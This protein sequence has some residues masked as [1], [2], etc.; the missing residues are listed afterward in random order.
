MRGNVLSALV[1]T[2][3]LL[4]AACVNLRA[5]DSTESAKET[6]AKADDSGKAKPPKLEPAKAGDAF[7]SLNGD[8]VSSAKIYPTVANFSSRFTQTIGLPV[9]DTP[10]LKIGNTTL[11]PT[12][13]ETLTYEDN[14]FAVSRKK[15]DD[16]GL[17]SQPGFGIR[18][19]FSDKIQVAAGYAFGWYDYLDDKARDYL[20]HNANFAL[21][22]SNIGVDGLSINLYDTYAQTGN[23]G[24]LNESYLAFTRQ[25]QNTSGAMVNYERERIAVS[26]SYD[27]TLLN[28]FGSSDNDYAYHTINAMFAYKVSKRIRPYLKYRFQSYDFAPSDLNNYTMNEVLG[29]VIFRP[30]DQ[31]EFDMYLG[32]QRSD[33]VYFDN[34]TEGPI[35]G[36]RLNYFHNQRITAHFA[37][38]RGYEVGVLT[39][40]MT[41]S[42]IEA[43]VTC[44]I[45]PELVIGARGGWTKE[46]RDS[47]EDQRTVQADLLARYQFRRQFFFTGDYRYTGRETN[48]GGGYVNT[49]QATIGFQWRY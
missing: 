16:W 17:Y 6:G 32:G 12:Y 2:G 48:M 11:F 42:S 40:G 45:S 34:S 4:M 41:V 29:G 38:S 31:F 46:L 13:L 23:T 9:E 10:G 1:V 24:V 18:H 19:R 36:M 7:A 39:G 37:A 21:N 15:Q 22:L 5:E 44:K 30:Y 33:A 26:A 47:G 8:E 25:H 43:G 3:G 35:A 28:I 27:Y 49:N 14:L 20:T